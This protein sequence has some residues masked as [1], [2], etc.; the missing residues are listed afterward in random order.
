[1]RFSINGVNHSYAGFVWEK[2]EF[3]AP[4][5][6]YS[7]SIIK[8]SALGRN[9]YDRKLSL[10]YTPLVLLRLSRDPY[11]CQ[12]ALWGPWELLLFRLLA[13][14]S[15]KLSL[16]PSAELRPSLKAASR[17]FLLCGNNLSVKNFCLFRVPCWTKY[18]VIGV[19]Q[20]GEDARKLVW[21][22]VTGY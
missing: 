5:P 16:R 7:I 10:R 11:A 8:C 6:I 1:M 4:S 14:P 9:Y 22:F 21:T 15:A 2:L 12:F 20:I 18:F 13:R 19:E 17:K 3:T